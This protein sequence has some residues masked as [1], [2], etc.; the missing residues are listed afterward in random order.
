MLS[1]NFIYSLFSLL[2]TL[3]GVSAIYIFLMADFLAVVN[4]IIAVGGLIFLFIFGRV[5]TD[6]LLIVKS[7]TNT[8]RKYFSAGIALIVFLL[9]SKV[10][11]ITPWETNIPKPTNG[12]IVEFAELLISKYLLHFELLSVL[13]LLVLVVDVFLN[14]R[15]WE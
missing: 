5:L 12:T 10:I 8:V 3:I 9:I 7:S 1:H 4:L 15:K 6:R 13:L 2:L 11:L 14:G